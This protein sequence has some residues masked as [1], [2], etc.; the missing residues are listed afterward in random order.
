MDFWILMPLM[1]VI[2]VLIFIVSAMKP[3]DYKK[4]DKQVETNQTTQV[5]QNVCDEPIQEL[6]KR[7][8]E[9]LLKDYNKPLPYLRY[10]N[11]MIDTIETLKWMN[12]HYDL[13]PKNENEIDIR[14]KS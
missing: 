4:L 7:V 1:F 6:R 3:I 13:V 12:E 14:E 11:L 10:T 2:L 8:V 5:E 9:H